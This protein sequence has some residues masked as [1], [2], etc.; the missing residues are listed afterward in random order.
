MHRVCWRPGATGHLRVP[1]IV[2]SRSEKTSFQTHR[3]IFDAYIGKVMLLCSTL[4][5][6]RE[7]QIKTTMR[8]HYTPIRMAKIQNT[9]DTKWLWS[10]R[11]S[12]A[13]L[14]GRYNGPTM[15]EDSLVVS[16]KMGHTFTI[17]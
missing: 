7:L 14:V 8:S 6:I 1:R 15:L 13:L 10:N 11:N 3:G 5:I 4:C 12:H 9:A 2:K 16:Y 17:W